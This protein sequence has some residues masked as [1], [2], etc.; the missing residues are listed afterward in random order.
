MPLKSPS[1]AMGSTRRSAL[2]QALASALALCGAGQAWAQASYPDKALRVI[3]PQPPGGGFDFVTRV[4]AERLG[5]LLGQSVVVENRPGSGTLVG[6]ELAAKAAPDGYTLLTGSVSNL[7]LNMGL[8]RNLP[9][10]SLRDFEPLGLAVAYSYSLMAR[11]DLAQQSLKDVI[12]FA[13]ANPGKLTYASAGNGSG[14]HV[15]A[16]ALWHLAGVELTHVPYRG[17]Q[18]AY[19]DLLGG[20]VDVFFDLSSTAR[21]Q[22]DAGTVRALAVSGNARLANHPDVPTIVQTG[23]A[24]LEL[25]S[26]FGFFAPARTPPAIVERLRSEL[27]RVIAMPEVI[28]IF[29]KAGGKPLAM[30]DSETR[31]LVQRDVERWTKLVRDMHLKPE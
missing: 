16:A 19:Q 1:I 12:A 17:A 29:R 5:K 25:E 22:I 3:V 13:N 14:Q 15:L 4:L 24:Q 9:Y 18:P 31:A 2:I 26:W 23:V 11:K 20:R 21:A 30:S 8:Y 10:D 6:T 28:D 27:A 7:A